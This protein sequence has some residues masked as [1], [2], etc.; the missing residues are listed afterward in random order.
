MSSLHPSYALQWSHGQTTVEDVLCQ[1]EV[2]EFLTASMEPR[3]NDRGRR[4][5]TS[6]RPAEP[7]CFNGATANR[8]WKTRSLRQFST[9]SPRLQ[10]SHGQS[11]VEDGSQ[12]PYLFPANGASMEPRPIDRGRPVV[13]NGQ[14]PDYVQLQWSHGQS[15]VED[16]FTQQVYHCPTCG[17]QWSHGQST[18]E[19]PRNCC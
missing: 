7:G 15:T 18:V 6:W 17:L 12:K 14:V 5:R 19:D 2:R 1:K 16:N 8:P 11:T 13:S 3:P 4:R 9:H 10:W